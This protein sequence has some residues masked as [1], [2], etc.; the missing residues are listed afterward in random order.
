MVETY[1]RDAWA[2]LGVDVEFVQHNHSRSSRGTLR[3]H[4]LPD[5]ARPG[6]AGPL[7]ARRDPRRRRRPAPRLADL[8]PVGGPRPRRRAPPPALRPGRLRPRLRGPQ[9][10]AD[11]TY[12]LSS[13]YDPATEAGIAWN[14]PDVG[15]EWGVS[16]PAALRAR[17][18]GARASPRSPSRCRS[19]TGEGQGPLPREGARAAGPL[20]PGRSA[21]AGCAAAAS[22]CRPAAS[23][24][25]AA[26]TSP[27][28]GASSSATS[29]SSAAS[30]PP[31][32]C[33]T[34][35]AGSAGWRS[36]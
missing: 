33:S 13:L 35:A 23:R 12:L 26:A 36:R 2:E 9:R 16:E 20:R 21:P 15:V 3:G 28:P 7:R 29:P 4:P 25:S 17:Q 30:S 1:S 10:V 18:I 31:T 19:S 11:V 6:E 24:S 8:R 27:R 14:D 5:R 22:W 34:S 32:G